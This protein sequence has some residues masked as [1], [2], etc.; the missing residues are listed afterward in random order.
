MSQIFRIVPVRGGEVCICKQTN[1]DGVLTCYMLTVYKDF[2][3]SGTVLFADR[4]EQDMYFKGFGE[5]G[6]FAGDAERFYSGIVKLRG[7][8]LQ[9]GRLPLMRV[10]NN[11]KLPDSVFLDMLK[12][13]R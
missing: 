12:K 3:F 9:K 2:L 4:L 13:K 8:A 11:E 1:L 7:E 6:K 5:S 10:D